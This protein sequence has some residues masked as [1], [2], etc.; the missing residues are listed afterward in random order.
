[1]ASAF[2]AETAARSPDMTRTAVSSFASIRVAT[3]QSIAFLASGKTLVAADLDGIR[4]F[5][6][7]SGKEVLPNRD[8]GTRIAFSADSQSAV[9]TENGSLVVADA[10]SG[11]ERRQWLAKPIFAG[12]IL[13]F[14]PNG[15]SVVTAVGGIAHRW[16]IATGRKLGATEDKDEMA[17]ASWLKI[18]SD[19]RR[20]AAGNEALIHLWDTPT[21]KELGRWQG[22]HCAAM[23]S[24]L[25]TVALGTGGT[26]RVVDTGTGK[27]LRS[28]AGYASDV[29]FIYTTP[30][31]EK[32][33]DGDPSFPLTFSP[34]A[35]V[36][37]ASGNA[38]NQ[39]ETTPLYLWNIA[40]GKRLPPVFW[41]DQFILRHIS[42][43]PDSCSLAL[44]RSDCTVCLVSTATGR[45]VRRFR[46][47]RDALTAPPAF[48]RDGRL[49]LTAVGD[50]LQVWEVATGGEVCRHRGHKGD[51]REL[52]VA[53]D[54]RRVATVSRDHTIL[55]WDLEHLVAAEGAFDADALSRDLASPDAVRGRRA[56]ETL[57]GERAQA[58]A[59]LRQHAKPVA[60]PDSA[61]VAQW[62]ADLGS[63]DFDRRN[64]AASALER[65]AELAGPALRKAAATAATLEARRRIE[66]LLQ[67]LEDSGP[68]TGER[69]RTVRVVQVLESI[70]TPEARKVLEPLARG[71]A[72]ARLTIEAR[73]AL[74]RLASRAA[75]T[76]DRP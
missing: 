64:R 66:G 37:L 15:Q 50:L 51:I 63:D 70:A 26:L 46:Q 11:R 27:L 48:T 10:A 13:A 39:A 32:R 75:A 35:T 69:L 42:F 23:S 12:A 17:L 18:S 44:M 73:A 76:I 29:S 61:Q 31:G 7:A 14:A 28:L 45:E 38:K 59:M 1:M 41:G 22:E 19:G 2:I 43:S 33:F 36:L 62:I 52:V 8:F 74:E 57:A 3:H 68:L 34:N 4:V 67:K 56:I 53:A 65:L 21:G 24:D 58:L 25:R 47:C 40:T 9:W 20:I 72:G 55:V 30:D 54:G 16:D 60:A 71:A 5:D 6:T 49:L